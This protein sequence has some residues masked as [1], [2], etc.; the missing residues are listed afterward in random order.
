LFPYQDSTWTV[1]ALIGSWVGKN[2]PLGCKLVA[3]MS[4]V[5]FGA[6]LGLQCFHVLF[7]ALHDWI[8]L[9]SLN[10]LKA[11]RMANSIQKL[12]IGTLNQSHALCDWPLCKCCSLWQRLSVVVG[13]VALDQLWLFIHR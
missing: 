10:D 5:A 8:P 3:V 4:P 6:L 13:P 7:L 11:V 2:K 1:S 12:F 9:G